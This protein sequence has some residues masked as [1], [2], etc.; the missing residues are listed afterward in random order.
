MTRVRH[1]LR[2]DKCGIK[3]LLNEENILFKFLQYLDMSSK[4]TNLVLL[5]IPLSVVIAPCSN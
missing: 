4:K 5:P 1:I 2:I 3:Y